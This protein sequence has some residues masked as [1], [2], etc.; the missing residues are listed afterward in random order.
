MYYVIKPI[1]FSC[2]NNVYEVAKYHTP[3]NLGLGRNVTAMNLKVWNGLP[4]DIQKVFTDLNPWLQEKMYKACGEAAQDGVDECLQHGSEMITLPK[5]ETAKI[6][7]LTSPITDQWAKDKD[8][9]GLP[10]TEVLNFA[11]GLLGK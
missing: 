8:D 11:R 7:R 9:K 3:T 6:E 1:I 4:S 5:E 2:A 10:G